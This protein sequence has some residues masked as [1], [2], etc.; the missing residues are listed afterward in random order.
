MK[1][2]IFSDKSLLPPDQLC[3]IMLP[4]WEHVRD[5][6]DPDA[7]RFDKY[8]DN[9]KDFFELV[10]SVE[11]AEVLVYPSVPMGPNFH[12]FERQSN[13]KIVIAFFNS[14]SCEKLE[15]KD[16]TY[17][18]RTSFNKSSQRK[19]EF[20][21]PGWSADFGVFEPRGW[22]INP[23]VSF[24]GQTSTPIRSV[25]LRILEKDN[26]INTEFLRR[27]EFCAGWLSTG[28]NKEFGIKMKREFINNISQGDY[29]F[30]AR[31]GGNFSYRLYET[32]M[33]GRIP[34][35]INTDC[36]LPYDFLINWC[37]Y[38]PIVDENEINNISN[39]LLEFHNRFANND[40][41][42][43]HQKVIRKMWEDYISPVGYFK[44]LHKH[45][46]T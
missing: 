16:N 33:C 1:L 45:F 38:F 44:N 27:G 36:V 24:C 10:N 26:R 34:L 14:D 39:K 30:C 20:S 7:P 40:D 35:L 19:K 17:I 11:E 5:F 18:F 6:T 12:N 9:G 37:E 46:I 41:F 15:Y 2:K 13:G 25:G 21:L 4:F 28:R 3:H 43:N 8:I 42:K 31:G 22:Q 23:T 29:V 32:M